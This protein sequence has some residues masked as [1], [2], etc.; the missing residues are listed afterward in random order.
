MVFLPVTDEYIVPIF[1]YNN[2]LILIYSFNIGMYCNIVLPIFF[3][4]IQNHATQNHAT[5]AG[6]KPCDSSSL[7]IT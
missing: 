5:Q 4:A 7:K 2:M 6:S 1:L 3:D